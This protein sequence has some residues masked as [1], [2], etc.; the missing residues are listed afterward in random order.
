MGIRRFPSLYI[1]LVSAPCRLPRSL[2]YSPE[3][4]RHEGVLLLVSEKMVHTLEVLTVLECNL[5]FQDNQKEGALQKQTA[6]SIS[7]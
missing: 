3:A 4:E 1:S 5:H 2:L 7:P 6:I